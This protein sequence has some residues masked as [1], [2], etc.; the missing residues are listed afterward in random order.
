MTA[1]LVFL[2]V[3][4]K[5]PMSISITG[6]VV[7]IT[8]ANELLINE[9]SSRVLRSGAGSWI[10]NIPAAVSTIAVKLRNGK[11]KL[12]RSGVSVLKTDIVWRVLLS[13]G[14]SPYD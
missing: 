4:S 8:I 3:R 2:P 10:L 1:I 7:A 12:L 5:V 9:R 14:L 13:T 11:Y 6:R